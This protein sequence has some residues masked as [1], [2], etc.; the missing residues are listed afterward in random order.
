[1]KKFLFFFPLLLLFGFE[2]TNHDLTRKEKKFALSY[3]EDT[4]N[5]LV[6]T[7]AGLTEVQFNFKAAPDRWSIKECIQHIAIAETNIRHMLDSVLSQP[8]NPEK[9]SEIKITDDQLIK[10]MTDRSK[11]FQAPETFQPFKSTFVTANDALNDFKINR[12]KLI[13]FVKS[14][15]IDM[16]NHISPSPAGMMD[17]YQM[18]LTIA[19][20]SNRHTQQIA[21]V[22][23]DPAFPK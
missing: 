13:R 16:R 21:E 6:K 3:L 18:V 2:V 22:K 1:M 9:K 15:K 10:M 7:V 14:S 20:H 11:K 8:M 5:D 19:A 17:A 4:R 23:A 12:E